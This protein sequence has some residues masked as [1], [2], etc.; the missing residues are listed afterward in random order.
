MMQSAKKEMGDDIGRI[1]GEWDDVE[2]IPT[3]LMEFDVATGGG[4]PRGKVS[5]LFGN[6]SSCKTVHAMLAVAAHQR[7]YPDLVC[8]YVA[9]EGYSKNEK[10][11]FAVLG[12]D[13]EKLAVFIPTYA[14]QVVDIVD[15][16]LWANDAGL[17]VLDSLAVMM[18]QQQFEDSAEKKS[19]GGAGVPISVMGRKIQTA[20]NKSPSKPT[21]IFINQPRTKIGVMYGDPTTLPGGPL[22]NHFLPSLKVRLYGKNE[23]DT[24]FSKVLPVRKA[25]TATLMKWKVPVLA[26]KAEYEAV[27]LPHNGLKVGQTDWFNTFKQYA[28]VLGLLKKA[29][30]KGAKG[31][32]CY[33]KNWPTLDALKEELYADPDLCTAV[34][35]DLIAAL[36][37]DGSLIAPQGAEE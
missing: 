4:F 28:T 25:I 33:D 36:A 18:T 31:W 1:G 24:K 11:W 26:M 16:F 21:I 34:T 32:V 8:G 35:Q 14:E 2:R 12:V 19:M 27:M 17:L 30:G 7:M 29:E 6:E 37:N 22:V 9:L 20:L 15:S 3:G 13:V 10:A 5:L 23:M